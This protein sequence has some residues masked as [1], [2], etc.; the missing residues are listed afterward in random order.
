MSHLPHQSQRARGSRGKISRKR[1][2]RAQTHL[3][4]ASRIRHIGHVGCTR[5]ELADTARTQSVDV[6]NVSVPVV[7]TQAPLSTRTKCMCSER[8]IRIPRAAG[9]RARAEQCRAEHLQEAFGE[10]LEFVQ[11]P[12]HLCRIACKWAR[13]T[14]SSGPKK[15]LLHLKGV[16]QQT[17]SYSHS[18]YGSSVVV[19]QNSNHCV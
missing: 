4:H 16:T 9:R 19:H 10:T 2:G 13:I 5:E 6:V 3:T 14:P 7:S 1:G 15:Q 8:S 17:I 12:R 11:V 18:N